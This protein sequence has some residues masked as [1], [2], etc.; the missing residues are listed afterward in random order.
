MELGAEF[1]ALDLARRR[2]GE[3]FDE[4]DHVWVLISEQ[5]PFAP[6]P[7][8]GCERVIAAATVDQYHR[9]FDPRG[10]I[11]LDR[12]HRRLPYRVVFDQAILD[13]DRTHPEAADLHHVVDAAL[14]D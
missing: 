10:T 13:L 9:G 1:V 12:H 2:A 5:S 8:L 7:E 6:L 4:F 3:I 11:D 14:V